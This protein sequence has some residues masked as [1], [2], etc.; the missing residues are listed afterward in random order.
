M[1]A[2]LVARFY[3]SERYTALKQDGSV[4]KEEAWPVQKDGVKKHN[5]KLARYLG[6]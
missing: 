5:A 6:E 3:V 1:W 2:S 4:K